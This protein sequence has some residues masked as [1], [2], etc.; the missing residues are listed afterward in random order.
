MSLSTTQYGYIVDPMVPFTDDKGKTIK[1]GFIRVFMAGTSTPVLT[2]RNYDGAT[3]QEKIELDNSGRVKHNV[4]GSKGS[5]YKVVVYN[6]LHSQE[7][8]LLTVDKIAVLGASINASGATI[9]T[10]LDN[11]TVQEENFLKATVEG[12]EVELALDPTEVTGEVSTTSAAETAAP[13]YV[14]PLLDKTGEGDSKKISLA[15][16]FKFAL[17]WIS[18]LATTITSFASGDFI[19]VSNTTYGA[20]KMSKDSLLELTAQN[21]LAGN[22][23][24]VFVPNSTNAV[25]GMPY[26]Y[27][28]ELY[29]AK[30]DYSGAWDASKFTKVCVSD[31]FALKSELDVVLVDFHSETQDF[32]FDGDVKNGI[33]ISASGVI[34]TNA[35]RA[36]LMF[37]VL[38][39]SE[40]ITVSFT[41]SGLVSWSWY[42]GF[43]DTDAASNFIRRDLTILTTQTVPTGAKYCILTFDIS[44]TSPSSIKIPQA[45]QFAY[46][47]DVNELKTGVSNLNSEVGVLNERYFKESGFA[48][49]P[50]TS[51]GALAGKLFKSVK[52]YDADGL[53]S[54]GYVLHSLIR[55]TALSKIQINIKYGVNGSIDFVCK[56]PDTSSS[57]EQHYILL[58]KPYTR[59]IL[60]VVIDWDE[61]SGQATMDNPDV[62][63]GYKD[64]Y[65]IGGS[66]HESL[67]DQTINQAT[68][69]C[70][71]RRADKTGVVKYVNISVG[72]AGDA[73][74][75]VGEVDQ[76]LLFVPR[77]K[78]SIVLASGIN[79][80]DMT[81][82]GI[83]IY[84]GEQMALRYKGKRRYTTFDGSA[85]SPNSFYYSNTDTL[86]LAEHGNSAKI[87][88]FGF[89][90]VVSTTASDVAFALYNKN[91]DDIEAAN[92]N[93]SSVVALQGVVKD[94]DGNPYRLL[95]S[96]GNVVAIP[97]NFKHILC[98]GNS[99][100]V[101]PTV[102]DNRAGLVTEYW[103]G[104]WSMAA[105]S[106]DIAWTTLLQTALRAARN[107]N[108]AD[109]KT[110]FGRPYEQGGS[111]DAD[112]SFVYWDENNAVKNFFTNI[113]N[114][115]NTD[116]VV[117]FLAEN[118]SGNDIVGWYSALIDKF[119]AL[120]PTAMIYCVGS[121]KSSVKANAMEGV[122]NAKNC[123]FIPML[124]VGESNRIGSFVLGDDGELHQ[125]DYAGVGNHPG[126]YGQVEIGAKILEGLNINQVIPT[127]SVTLSDARLSMK[128][129]KVHA[130]AIVSIFSDDNSVTSVSA[131]SGAVTVTAH[132]ATE[133]GNV[134]TFVMPSENV[135]VTVN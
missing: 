8:P 48:A 108:S 44:G 2:Y 90:F 27:G 88:S 55:N 89:N 34:G 30:E 23:A 49:V 107:D 40:S 133:W 122:A 92:D 10:G 135:I 69:M 42:T 5:L 66:E 99:Y 54:T 79:N 87:I 58:S 70:P 80:L 100:T 76:Y 81:S 101:H 126:D 22:V 43:P 68:V 52:F 94:N 11:V 127:Y 131:N 82:L 35:G 83:C 13:D 72:E 21:A 6:I 113:S 39:G 128:N 50:T 104:H 105:S 24:P 86:Q 123:P 95:I 9:V 51:G 124:N 91:K 125:I 75:L 1:N 37:K 20:R 4:I 41:N 56:D 98:V 96:S 46:A 93:I 38:D 14:V 59:Q 16:I 71:I 116:C 112:T 130:G 117:L 65:C 17:D 12:T 3:N 33:A 29:V 97:L 57:G 132:L 19:A 15:N 103:W 32:V 36:I 62:A 120:F 109:V 106:K 18:R 7:N 84:E 26:V 67:S 53:S 73:E 77:K 63:E 111:I 31:A 45:S 25:A 121:R 28:G 64:E 119:R 85:T 74:L 115:S 114:F 78:F 102:D 60:D 47:G 61:Y 110:V 134:F 129:K 118:Y